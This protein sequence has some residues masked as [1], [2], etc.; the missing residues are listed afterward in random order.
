M[1]RTIALAA[2]I[3][4]AI[5]PGRLEAQDWRTIS[6]SRM[7]GKEEALRVAVKYGAGEMAI[8]PGDRELLYQLSLRYDADV[9]RPIHEFRNGALTVGV[10]G[11]G[12]TNV[13][14]GG[15][16]R[17][18]LGTAVPIDLDLSFGAAAAEME[19]GGMRIRRA[20]IQTGA[21]DTNLSFSRP[22]ADRME[23]LKVEAGAAAVRARGLGN[24]NVERITVSGGV[25][26]VDL[27]FSGVWRGDTD[28]KVDLGL[29]SLTLRVPRGVGVRVDR[30]TFLVGFD[31]EGLVKR[32][33]SYYS[34]NWEEAEHLLTVEVNGAFGAINIRWIE[35]D[36][37]V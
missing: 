27:D 10:E 22:N 33:K 28:V 29:G 23:S 12:K 4:L 25:G 16:L 13:R 11:G 17:L 5:A 19:L 26:D 6:S 7:A 15:R 20:T 14:N 2:A 37:A 30:S 18:V 36:E 3:A 34:P 8:E 21:S 24:A 9:F 35:P 1:S 31:S 32:G